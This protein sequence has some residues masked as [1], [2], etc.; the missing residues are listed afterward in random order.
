MKILMVDP[1]GGSKYGFPKPYQTPYEEQL[2]KAGYPEEDINLALKYSR[3][4]EVD[5]ETHR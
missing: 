2:R 5:D 1:P 3:F 4:W